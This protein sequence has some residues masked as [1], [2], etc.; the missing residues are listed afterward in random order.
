MIDEIIYMCRCG[1]SIEEIAE[2]LNV[3]EDYVFTI[4][5]ENDEL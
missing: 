1:Y 2:H 3:D 4:L 5:E